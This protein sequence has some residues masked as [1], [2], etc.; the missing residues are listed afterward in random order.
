MVDEEAAGIV[1]KKLIEV[2]C[3]RFAHAEPAGY[4]SDEI[5]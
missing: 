1:D 4:V 5:G 2:G 3:D